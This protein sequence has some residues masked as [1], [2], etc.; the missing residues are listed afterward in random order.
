MKKL[1]LQVRLVYSFILIALV[2]ILAVGILTLWIS[3]RSYHRWEGEYLGGIAREAELQIR[4]Y[5]ENS[6]PLADLDD[7]LSRIGL[8]NNVAL[9]LED[10]IGSM[11][12]QS[13]A[14]RDSPGS[15]SLPHLPVMPVA[16]RT[17]DF[18]PL[19]GHVLVVMRFDEYFYHPGL[20]LV[21]GI[22]LAALGA[23]VL[24]IILG[25]YSGRKIARPIARLSLLAAEIS[26]HRWD[27][28]L[29]ETNSRELELLTRSLG[30]MR[31]QLAAGFHTLEEER[32]VM[33]RFLQDASHQLRTPVTA[34]TT[35]LELLESDLP[36]MVQRREELLGD[37]RQQTEK[38][39][40][41]I[42]DLVELTRIESERSVRRKEFCSL[43]DLCRKAWKGVET[44]AAAKKIF[45]DLSGPSGE[46]SGDS[47]RLEMA[48]SNIM[49]NA[50]KWSPE[51]SRIS[52]RIE[53]GGD[54]VFVRISDQG[55]GIPTED[56]ER[57]FERFYQSYPGTTEGSGLGLAVVKRIVEDNGGRISA[58][59]GSDGGARFDFFLPAYK[60]I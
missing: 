43:K 13:S 1:S 21:P 39:S 56:N 20:L 35:F 50:V 40:R 15:F 36:D 54:L 27:G 23:V 57:I 5:M 10:G 19:E 42:G 60:E 53:S 22:A 7:A 49:D 14:L 17:L 16:R 38:L 32:D 46:V 55:P 28:S 45:L 24:A 33:K 37:C 18:P 25:R 9:R 2:S 31:R 44:K 26:Q 59:K 3:V 51:E 4:G 30:D 58:G 11:V 34:L 29:P 8:R 48:I 41:I 52:V 12:A 47:H 6:A